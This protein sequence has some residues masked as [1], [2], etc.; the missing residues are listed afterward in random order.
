MRNLGAQSRVHGS[1]GRRAL[2]TQKLTGSVLRHLCALTTLVCELH[3]QR[4]P[5]RPKK[6]CR[7]SDP[8]DGLQDR[9]RGKRFVGERSNQSGSRTGEL[10]TPQ[11]R[12]VQRFRTVQSYRK[13]RPYSAAAPPSARAAA[14]Q[15]PIETRAEETRQAVKDR[16][17]SRGRQRLSWLV[18]RVVAMLTALG[19][20]QR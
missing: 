18:G 20:L 7:S 12:R 16:T 8:T 9:P 10:P 3:N 14:A 13:R 17:V 1:P 15:H 11:K 6:A 4:P 2:G 5:R 19:Y